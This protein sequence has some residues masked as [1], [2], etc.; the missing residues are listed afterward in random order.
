C[1]NREI[2]EILDLMIPKQEITQETTIMVIITVIWSLTIALLHLV[3]MKAAG[4][5]TAMN[6]GYISSAIAQA[7]ASEFDALYTRIASPGFSSYT[8]TGYPR[9]IKF[10]RRDQPFYEFTNF[11]S[12][13]FEDE[14]DQ[15]RIRQQNTPRDALEEAQRMRDRV[16]EGWVE[17]DVSIQMMLTT[18]LHKFTQHDSLRQRLLSTGDAILIE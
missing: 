7:A 13:M 15:E 6:D 17:H 10:Y 14:L 4:L 18:L 1:P 12:H 11:S 3:A 9:K 5:H 16:R 2:K 8:P